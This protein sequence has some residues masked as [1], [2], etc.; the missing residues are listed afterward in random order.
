[1]ELSKKWNTSNSIHNNQ[2]IVW[3]N[4]VYFDSYLIIWLSIRIGNR[5][6]F[7][8]CKF[9]SLP[10][11]S[12]FGWRRP[13][14]PDLSRRSYHPHPHNV[15]QEPH[16]HLL[17]YY[18]KLL[19]SVEPEPAFRLGKPRNPRH[20]LVQCN[21]TPDGSTR[22]SLWGCPGRSSIPPGLPWIWKLDWFIV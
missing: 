19:Y 7:H 18:L 15:S 22:P 6:H 13:V 14:H 5:S 2:N 12:T 9:S 3:N 1:M 21:S 4:R 20:C 8:C 17:V 16:C 11:P 10:S